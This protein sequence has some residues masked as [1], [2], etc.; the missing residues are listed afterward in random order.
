MLTILNLWH[1]TAVLLFGIVIS[2]EIAGEGNV[3]KYKKLIGTLFLAL[4]L[5]Q[6]IFV[7]LFDTSTVEKLYPLITHLPL[8]LVLTVLFEKSI[9]ISIISVCTAYLCCQIPNWG[10]IAVYAYTDSILI[11]EV[12]YN[13]L[14]LLTYVFLHRYVVQAT[15]NVMAYSRRSLLLF[16]GLPLTYY[17]FDY[18]TTVYSNILYNSNS[19][20]I[21]FLPTVLILF[22]VL[23]ITAYHFQM[24]QYA[25]EEL[26]NSILEINQKEALTEISM[27]RQAEMRAAIYQHDMRHHLMMIDG[28]LQAN[29]PEQASSYIHK[30]EE[31]LIAFVPK[32]FCKNE[33][34]N[35]ICSFFSGKA[36]Q[37]GISIQTDIRL[38]DPL[39]VSD[40]ELCAILSN[41]LE[42]ALNAVSLTQFSKKYIKLYCDIRQNNLLIEILNP[43]EGD[44]IIKDGIPVSDTPGHGY[45]CRSIQAIAEHH[46]GLAIFHAEDGLFTARVALPIKQKN[47]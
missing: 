4:L 29:Q 12:V 20:L 30:T 6:G 18:T 38:P 1:S 7:L 32:R 14:L 17:V 45:G 39:P 47:N 27:L 43:Y 34:V 37:L 41:G 16:G 3:T 21:E 2:L 44:C 19:V 28:F 33:S 5:L 42:N 40:T 26:R 35:L 25:Q 36:E 24:Q 15:Y 22:Y 13:A 8:V 10:N 11:S 46:K 31:D 23:F 9:G